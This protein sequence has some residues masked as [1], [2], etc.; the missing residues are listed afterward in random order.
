V[1][2]FC[3]EVVNN[4][5]KQTFNAQTDMKWR[6]FLNEVHQH[7]NSPRSEVQVGFRISGDGGP[8]LY[9]ATEHDWN[10]AIAWLVGKAQAAQTRP[11]SMEV[12]NMV[13]HSI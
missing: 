4:N 12:K 10:L 11:A 3:V 5:I 9:L 8:M 2:E 13:R 6:D 7:L 1:W